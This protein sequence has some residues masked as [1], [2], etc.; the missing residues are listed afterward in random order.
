VT[1][2]ASPAS[3]AAAAQV[4][5]NTNAPE[6]IIILTNGVTRYTFTSRGGGLKLVELL[7]MPQ[8][9]SARWRTKSGAQTMAWLR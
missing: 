1:A 7:N 4:V 8:T 3:S 6:Q 5:F 9:I 2:P